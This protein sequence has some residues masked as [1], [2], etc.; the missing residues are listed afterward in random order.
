[1]K[2]ISLPKAFA[3]VIQK[4]VIGNNSNMIKVSVIY[5]LKINSIN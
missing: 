3:K 2:C 4:I 5:K 1:M